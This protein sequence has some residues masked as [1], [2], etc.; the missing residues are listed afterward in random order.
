VRSPIDPAEAGRA[1]SGRIP[2]R[3]KA[4]AAAPTTTSRLLNERDSTLGSLCESIEAQTLPPAAQELPRVERADPADGPVAL[5]ASIALVASSELEH[6]L[7]WNADAEEECRSDHIEPT[8]S[9]TE[10]VGELAP[11]T[12]HLAKATA[13]DLYCDVFV[14]LLGEVFEARHRV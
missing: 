14:Q 13:D 2:E 10:P 8:R 12:G 7:G 11:H 6:I 5:V 9:D 1:L 3:P 4:A